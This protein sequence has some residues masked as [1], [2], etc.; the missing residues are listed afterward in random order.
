[1]VKSDGSHVN[2]SRLFPKVLPNTYEDS[3]EGIQ[4]LHR[5]HFLYGPEVYTTIKDFAATNK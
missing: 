1:M 3:T 4:A 5:P 2:C